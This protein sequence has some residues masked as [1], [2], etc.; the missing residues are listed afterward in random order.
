MAAHHDNGTD[1]GQ[2]Q[3]TSGPVARS[4]WAQYSRW[5]SRAVTSAKS[6]SSAAAAAAAAVAA[7]SKDAAAKGAAAIL[8]AV[9]GGGPVGND[10][11]ERVRRPVIRR[12]R[13]ADVAG[14]HRGISGTIEPSSFGAIS[15]SSAV[16]GLVGG[17][18]APEIPSADDWSA[19]MSAIT[20]VV[21]SNEDFAR[22]DKQWSDDAQ[23]QL[24]CNAA[25]AHAVAKATIP[26]LPSPASAARPVPAQIAATN[27]TEMARP[28]SVSTSAVHGGGCA[29]DGNGNGNDDDTS[30]RSAAIDS[31]ARLLGGWAQYSHPRTV[32]TAGSGGDNTTPRVWGE[33]PRPQSPQSPSPP[34]L[35]IQEPPTPAQAAIARG[36]STGSIGDKAAGGGGNYGRF[37][38]SRWDVASGERDRGYYMDGLRLA[39]VTGLHTGISGLIEP[40]SFGA[41]PLRS[42]RSLALEELGTSGWCV[43]P[44]T[45]CTNFLPPASLL[46]YATICAFLQAWG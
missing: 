42:S 16:C 6:K 39:D 12:P 27:E 5:S 26:D 20:S 11:D 10:Q 13:T 45:F 3:Q 38:Y 32:P 17:P 29:G 35:L 7:A 4:G 43:A 24:S 28:V 36:A 37:G 9:R 25:M 22:E 21:S 30:K 18:A 14:V 34:Q 33:S 19:I 15:S 1:T 40:S 2:A 46:Q 8:P 23:G 41:V 44:S 31:M